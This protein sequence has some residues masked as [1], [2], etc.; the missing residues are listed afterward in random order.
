MATTRGETIPC[1]LKGKAW[2][3]SSYHDAGIVFHMMLRTLEKEFSHCSC[4]RRMFDGVPVFSIVWDGDFPLDSVN[5]VA[6]YAAEIAG[7][8]ELNEGVTKTILY[9]DHH[10]AELWV[11][12]QSKEEPNG[13]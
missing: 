3:M 10:T 6:W 9:M 5:F 13:H 2:K 8:K 11:K 4:A 7:G 1:G 12:H